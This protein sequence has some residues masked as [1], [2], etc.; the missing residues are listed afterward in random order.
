VEHPYRDWPLEIVIA[1]T[2]FL[3][4]SLLGETVRALPLFLT[5]PF[6]LMCIL[7][8]FYIVRQPVLNWEPESWAVISAVVLVLSGGAT[9][10]ITSAI[11]DQSFIY[12]VAVNSTEPD[13]FRFAAINSTFENGKQGYTFH[14]VF[15][16]VADINPPTNAFPAWLRPPFK[17]GDLDRRYTE[18]NLPLIRRGE[19]QIN[20]QSEGQDFLEILDLSSDLSS[21]VPKIEVRRFGESRVLFRSPQ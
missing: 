4:G 8:I 9:R 2:F 15:V 10:G 1:V 13:L 5:I 17:I 21:N 19:Y 6:L 3:L 16:R 7:R 14:N 18:L 11:Y 20:L 12:L